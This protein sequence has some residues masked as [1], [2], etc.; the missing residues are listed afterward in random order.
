MNRSWCIVQSVLSVTYDNASVRERVSV[1]ISYL[2]EFAYTGKG[3]FSIFFNMKVNL[4]NHAK[5]FFSYFID[6]LLNIFA[7]NLF[8]GIFTRIKYLNSQRRFSPI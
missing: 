2:A 4:D 6:L 7:V 1:N 3:F 8:L 5:V